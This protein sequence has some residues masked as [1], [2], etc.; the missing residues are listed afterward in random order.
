VCRILCANGEELTE[1]EKCHDPSQRPYKCGFGCVLRRRFM[2]FD[3]TSN[4]L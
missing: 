1:H 4:E 2:E 3:E